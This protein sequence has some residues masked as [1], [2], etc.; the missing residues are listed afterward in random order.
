MSVGFLG[1]HWFVA[2]LVSP[3]DAEVSAWPSIK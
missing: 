1:S 3:K 2:A